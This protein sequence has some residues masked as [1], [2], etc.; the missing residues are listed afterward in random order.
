MVVSTN[1]YWGIYYGDVVVD[2]WITSTY[3][4]G[5]EKV[6]YDCL[7]EAFPE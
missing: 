3:L 4:S 1:M 5:F 6:W 7:N 2:C